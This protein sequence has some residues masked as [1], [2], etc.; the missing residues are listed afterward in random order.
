MTDPRISAR[1]W[2]SV[3]AGCIA[4]AA[5]AAT[6]AMAGQGLKQKSRTVATSSSDSR[7]D[8]VRVRCGKGT[9]AVSGGFRTTR[10]DDPT[11]LT[12]SESRPRAARRWSASA[13]TNPF[14]TTGSLTVLA[15]CRD[16]KVKLRSR[17]IEVGTAERGTVSA[18]CPRGM[19]VVSGGFEAEERNLN[20]PTTPIMFVTTSRKLGARGWQ[21]S[22][23]NNGSPGTLTAFARCR[24]GPKLKTAQASAMIG[25]LAPDLPE[26][27]LSPRCRKRHRAVAGGFLTSPGSGTIVHATVRASQRR[28]GRRWNIYMTAAGIAPSTVTAYTYC[29]RKRRR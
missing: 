29:E 2:R 3:A 18:R 25:N 10:R 20:A 7:E 28:S 4:L 15:Y 9:R 14:A 27:D 24:K 23:V 26:A 1:A 5:L 17:S 6:S 16:E 8:S 11:L 13:W 19:R 12:V 21:V 22:A